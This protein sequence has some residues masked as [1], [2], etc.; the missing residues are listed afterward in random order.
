MY[1]WG[2]YDVQLCWGITR[3]GGW[4]TVVGKSSSI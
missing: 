2:E 1:F 3:E 4:D